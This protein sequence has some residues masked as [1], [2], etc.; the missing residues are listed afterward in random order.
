M[1]KRPLLILDTE[2]SGLPKH[3]W[4]RVI[5]I[6][7]VAIDIDG[8]EVSTFDTL[9]RPLDLPPE[10]DEALALTGI[11]RE[12]LEMAPSA[13]AVATELS[14]WMNS[15]RFNDWTLT[16]F[17]TDFDRAMLSRDTAWSRWSEPTWAACIMRAAH[18]IMDADASCPLQRWDNG[19]LKWPKLSEAATYFGVEVCEPQ[20]RALGDARTAA[21]IVKA[22]AQRRK[23]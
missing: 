1:L 2:T 15:R 21:E 8:H 5:E 10:A 22:I 4:S 9:V 18:R 19:E 14:Y 17:N 6:A 3:R 11:T 7:F 23:P 20:H 12:A 13:M 16:S